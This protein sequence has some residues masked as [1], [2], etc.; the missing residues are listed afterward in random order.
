MTLPFI[1]LGTALFFGFIIYR[2][3]SEYTSPLSKIPNAGFGAAFSRLAWAFPQEYNG[4]ITLSL[5]KFHERLG[6]LIRIGPNEVSFYSRDTYETV[7]KVGSKFKKDPRVYG[8]FVQGGHPALFS[9]TDPVEHAKRRRIMS[10][11]FS[12]SKVP[13]L[14]R[15]ISHHVQRFVHKIRN[16][17]SIVDLGV[18]SRALEADIMS[19]FSF[20][21]S[22]NAIDYWAGG[23]QLAMVEKNDEKATWMPVLTNFPLLCEFWE[24]IE[25]CLYSLTGF[26]T[27]YSQGLADF[28][29]WA[30]TSWQAA[31]SAGFQSDITSINSPNL[32]QT[33]CNA[34]LPAETALSEAG[35]N[36]GP[37]TDTTSATLAHIIWA[38]A[39]NPAYQDNLY[40][41]L[42]SVSFATDMTTLENI[43]RLQACV[44]EGIRWAGAAAAMLPRTVPPGGIELHGTFIPEGTVLISSP[45]WYLHDAK[46]YPSPK[47]FNPYR[48]LSQ[49]GKTLT[50]DSLRDRFYIPFS[51][52]ANICLGAHF[53]HL[54]LYV[55][56]SQFVRNFRF[57]PRNVSQPIADDETW[58]L[59]SLPERKEWVATV[60]LESLQVVIHQRE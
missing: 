4:T 20:G 28:Q 23:K 53:S 41:D 21:T 39:H 9:I 26:R 46:A 16:N 45:I 18:S 24:T 38:L 34:G 14:E 37:G 50:E 48:W 55:S 5:P 25:E 60:L 15:L 33:L 52:G 17:D 47:V 30:Q 6:P 42:A 3:I 56:I 35:E 29:N 27:Q 11:L 43:P 13:Q 22:I 12:R 2:V 31:L 40:Q 57:E 8:E 59:V 49:D 32:I 51:R 19:D 1:E 10:Q 36:L 54:E 58:N 7:H 44:K